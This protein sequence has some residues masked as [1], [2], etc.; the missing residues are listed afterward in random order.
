MTE[1]SANETLSWQDRLADK[2]TEAIGTMNFIF[3]SLGVITLWILVNV[4]GFA[5][6]HFDP[7]PFVFLNLAFSAFAFFSAPLILMSQNRQAAKDR[8][9]LLDDLSTDK[10]SSVMLKAIVEHL[11]VT[12]PV[13]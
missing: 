6:L 5:V 8:A 1:I 4:V 3:W 2:L 12:C 11:G 9:N 7:Y 13:P 10:Q